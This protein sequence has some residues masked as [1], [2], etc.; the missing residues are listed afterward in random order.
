MLRTEADRYSAPPPRPSALEERLAFPHFRLFSPRIPRTEPP[1]PPPALRP[2]EIV[3]V[4]RLGG[5]PGT[6]EATWFPTAAD[7]PRGAVLLLPPWLQWGRSYFHRR[8]R[9]PALRRAGYHVLSLD[10]PGFADSARPAGF[11]DLEVSAGLED[12]ARRAPGLPL[13]LWGVSAGGH[14]AHQALARE[15][16]VRAAFFEDVSPHLL[17]WGWRQAPAA[18]PGYLL[19]RLLYPRSYRF[20]DVRNHAPALRGRPAVY[21]SGELDRGVPPGD[22]KSVV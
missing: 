10:F 5:R 2:F 22:R 19:L 13:H 3:R 14:W 8:G 12:L 11:F 15:P 21:V 4:P 16:R 6:L 18:R 9:I 20:L 17:E 7:S 1:G